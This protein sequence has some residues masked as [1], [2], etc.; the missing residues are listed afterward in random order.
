MNIA[1]ETI[2]IRCPNWV[3]DIVMAAPVFDCIRENFPHAR[4]TGILSKNAQGIVRDGPWF[5][6][7]IDCE[8]KTLA[9]MRRMV[10]KIRA[11]KPDMA[12]LLTNSI[13]SILPVW[14][15]RSETYIR[16]SQKFT[17]DA[18]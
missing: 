9:G 18:P 14:L 17:G 4:I 16:L 3:G 15:G 6:D 5:D 13:R 12:I 7:F 11:L 8:D 1:V 10:K 2:L